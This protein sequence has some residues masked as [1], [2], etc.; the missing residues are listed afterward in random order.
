[1]DGSHTERKCPVCGHLAVR[2]WTVPNL[3]TDTNF[4]M[5]GQ[6]DSRLGSK[7][8]GRKDWKE[9]IAQKG[10]MEIDMHDL[11]NTTS[12]TASDRIKKAGLGVENITLDEVMR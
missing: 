3:Q 6:Y 8:E 5:T 11:K 2:I 10:L 7:V 1:M 4:I 9:K 12:Y